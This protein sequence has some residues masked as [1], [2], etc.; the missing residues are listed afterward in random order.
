MDKFHALSDGSQKS[1]VAR[2][3]AA[4]GREYGNANNASGFE[5]GG[6]NRRAG[7]GV[8]HAAAGDGRNHVNSGAQVYNNAKK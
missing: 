6:D 7:N 5:K 2:G 8:V 1:V 4:A 3:F